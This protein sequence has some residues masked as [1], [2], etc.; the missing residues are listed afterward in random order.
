MSTKDKAIK[1]L[2]SL[3]KDYTFKEAESLLKSLGFEKR[4]KGRTSGSRVGFF[5]HADQMVILLHKPHPGDIM[6]SAATKGLKEKLEER[7]DLN[8]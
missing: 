7:G 6:D 3:P 1:R 5:R 2:R 4:N 8:E